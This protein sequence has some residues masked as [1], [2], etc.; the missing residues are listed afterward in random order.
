MNWYY[1]VG[2]Q[3][4]GPLSEADF[5]NLVKAGT[6]RPETLIWHE[7]LTEW[8]P[9]R[10]IATVAPPPVFAGS[11]A[12]AALDLRPMGIGDILDRTFR[13]Y[14]SN[15]MAFFLV[16]LAVQAV[17]HVC[18]LGWQLTVWTQ[19]RSAGQANISPWPIAL[20]SYALIIPLLLVIFMLHQISIGTLT[21]AV[22]AAYLQQ[23][24]SIRKAFQNVRGKLGWLVGSA[25][26]CSMIVMLGL[27]LCIVPGI[28]FSLWFLLVG[29][30]VVLENQRPVAALRRSRELMRVKT[31]RGF[32]RH[33]YTKAG[34]ILL[35]TFA[36]GAIVGG[37]ISIPFA[38]VHAM[39]GT[40]RAVT[41]FAPLQL[42]QGVLTMT[43]Q[44]AIAPVGLIAMILF[45]YDIRI[46]KEGFDLEVL[47]AALGSTK[48]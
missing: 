27:L 26:L 21:A 13:V 6:I 14:R 42:L 19:I 20:G 18:M 11:S 3:Q 22:S 15:F 4:V 44:A 38:I 39:A 17:S 45:Y 1:A 28:Y 16:M 2:G 33:N 7:G 34:V 31:D 47:A 5:E 29:Q 24:V 32:A 30:V 9:Y 43:V 40:Q 10:E 37:I 12:A 35:I 46:R 25:L 36:L 48:P 23:E 41:P 8:R